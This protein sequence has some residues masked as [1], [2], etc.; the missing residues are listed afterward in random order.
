AD[1]CRGCGTAAPP[2]ASTKFS[3]RCSQFNDERATMTAVGKTRVY[4]TVDVECAEERVARGVI[5]PAL[6]YDLRVW[7]RFS[8]HDDELGVPLIMRELERYGHRGT[9]FVGPFGARHFGI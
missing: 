4:F 8:N 1:A 7:G 3:A 9:F 5:Q 6:G 2:S